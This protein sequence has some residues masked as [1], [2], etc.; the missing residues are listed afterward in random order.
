MLTKSLALG[1]CG[2][3]DRAKLWPVVL[4]SAAAWPIVHAKAPALQ[5][6]DYTPTFTV[7]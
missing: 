6:Y 1:Q 2:G 4:T 3:P 7:V 5:A